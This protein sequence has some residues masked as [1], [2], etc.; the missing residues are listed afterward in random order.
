MNLLDLPVDAASE[1]FSAD[2]EHGVLGSILFDNNAFDRVADVVVAG[3][4]HDPVNGA[5]FD[6]MARLIVSGRQADVITTMAELERSGSSS[7]IDYQTLGSFVD[8]VPSARAARQYA[9]TV[10]ENAMARRLQGAA[11]EVSAIANERA[12]TASDRAARAQAAIE[13]VVSRKG[14]GDPRPV[15]VFVA[16]ML[17]RVQAMADGSL[18]PGMPTRIPGIDRRIGGGLRT[19]KVYILA[20]RPSVGKSSLLGQILLNL[21]LDGTPVAAFSMEMEESENTNRLVSNLGRVDLDSLETGKLADDEWARLCDGVE[22]VR[23]LPL[24]LQFKPGMTLQWLGVKA[25]QLKRKHGV[26][27]I[28]IDYLQLMASANKAL[29]RHHQIEEISRGLKELAGI[30]D[31]AIVVL[32]QLNREVEKRTSGR[33]VMADLKE[34]GAAEEDADVVMLMWRHERAEPIS[35]IGLDIAKSRQGKTGEVA[36]AFEGRYQRWT[37]STNPL[38][39]HQ[40]TQKPRF[41]SDI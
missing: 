31:V 21:A 7:A 23:D 40:L 29:S 27:V 41:R 26:K 9:E 28:G 18:Q 16:D 1:F 11:R 36:L 37:E 33:P 20:A 10:A 12:D 13:A 24:F 15:E 25:R 8:A 34:S 14:G 39:P 4:F 5:V 38:T 22:R 6:A 2:A 32:S 30:L 35:T 3:D 19:K 17:D